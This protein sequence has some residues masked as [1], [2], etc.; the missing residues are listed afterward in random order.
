MLLI[1]N[2]YKT[3][4]LENDVYANFGPIFTTL[5][6][7]LGLVFEP[8]NYALVIYFQKQEIDLV[9]GKLHQKKKS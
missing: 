4:S 3:I 6:V 2:K 8:H 1:H 7:R 5:K 9:N